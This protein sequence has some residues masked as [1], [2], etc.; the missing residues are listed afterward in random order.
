MKKYLFFT[1][2]ALAMIAF[3]FSACWNRLISLKPKNQENSHSPLHKPR[4]NM[5][6][7]HALLILVLLLPLFSEAQTCP[8]LSETSFYSG[9]TQFYRGIRTDGNRIFATAFIYNEVRAFDMSGNFLFNITGFDEANGIDIAANGDLYIGDRFNDMVKVFDY[10]GNFKFSFNRNGMMNGPEG[11]K[12]HN[13]EVFVVERDADRVSVFSLNGAFLRNFTATS[14][15]WPEGIDI[16]NGKVYVAEPAINRRVSVF[17]LNGNLLAF[18]GNP[19]HDPSDVAVD[20]DGNIYIP[21]A[22]NYRVSKFDAAGNFLCY[23]NEG[24]QASCIDELNGVI[25]V[26]HYA[27]PLEISIY[28]PANPDAD[29]DGVP[30]EYD[31]CPNT[32]NPGQEDSDTDGYGDACD[33]AFNIDVIVAN[34]NAYIEGLNLTSGKANSLTNKLNKALEDYCSG[35]M[36]S[37]I[38]QL[39]AFKNHVQGLLNDGV[40]TIEE[41]QNLDEAADAIIAAINTGTVIC[42][43][44]AFI[45]PGNSFYSSTAHNIGLNVFPN[46]AH[47]KVDIRFQA[48]DARTKVTIFDIYGKQIWEQEAAPYQD[49]LNVDLSTIQT[50]MGIF[51][52]SACNEGGSQTQRVV[53][54]R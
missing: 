10:D 26:G 24:K 46:P 18:V 9:P 54:N 38:N 35:K 11:V 19:S 25:Y 43:I 40:L 53:I 31:N 29:A 36:T 34:T 23:V 48:T 47:D 13:N 27:Y 28:A 2:S 5:K 41:A 32:A 39:N 3:I 8:D 44:Q 12:I 21:E 37:A 15:R 45:S 33:P 49:I 51:I 30:D 14:L 20:T 22:N 7:A 6:Y 4:F 52:I 17:D 16:Q 50:G 1:L 42:P